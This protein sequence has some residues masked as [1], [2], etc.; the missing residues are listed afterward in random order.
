MN[1]QRIKTKNINLI[2]TRI[3]SKQKLNMELIQFHREQKTHT[4]NQQRIKYKEN[5]K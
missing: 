1:Q 2:N 4:T 3:K 5:M